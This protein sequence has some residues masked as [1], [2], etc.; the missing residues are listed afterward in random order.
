[1]LLARRIPEDL[2][3]APRAAPRS[4]ADLAKR[5]GVSVPVAWRFLS[6]LKAGGH[7]DEEGEVVRVPE[8]LARWRAA[9]QRPYRQVGAVWILPGR[10][11]LD[12]LRDALR[13]LDGRA[14]EPL[15]C[16]GLFAA[17][18]ALGLGH[19]TGA[20]VYL[21]VRRLVPALLER[22][23]F[24]LAPHGQAADVLLR[25]PR[26][27]QSVFRGAV[28]PSGIPAADVLQ[29]WLDVSAEPARGA[30]QATF[31]WKRVIGPRLA[32]GEPE[33]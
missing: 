16:L 25:V 4:G 24:G 11:P 1:M 26:W 19:V 20:P 14:E 27:P 17:C 9:A 29:C 18:D 5:A 32:D 12:R 6:A 2:L 8:L 21:Y 33:P 23:G 22:L 28:R 10:A 15:A 31:L 13:D 7:L 3:S 30:E